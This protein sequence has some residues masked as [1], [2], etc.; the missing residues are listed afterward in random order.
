MLGQLFY[1]TGDKPGAIQKY[2]DALHADPD[3]KS[4]QQA[5]K[6]EAGKLQG[7]SIN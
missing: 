7:Q 1:Q 3:Y 2:R 4:A 6:R 5:L